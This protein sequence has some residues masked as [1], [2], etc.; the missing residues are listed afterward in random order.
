MA[1]RSLPKV[2]KA[3]AVLAVALPLLSSVAGPAPAADATAGAALA[4]TW[5]ASCHLLP[6]APQS[7][8]QPGPPP[9]KAIADGKGDA[10]ELRS[11]LS[12]PHG[13][14]PN[15][16]LSRAEIDNVIAYIQSLR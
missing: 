12:H 3:A 6:S 10:E 13:A 9:F 7:S 15:L 8:V 2:Q 5:C 1:H 11:F 4:Q 16:S 14:M